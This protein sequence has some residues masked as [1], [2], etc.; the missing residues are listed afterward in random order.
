[1]HLDPRDV[2]VLLFTQYRPRVADLL[3]VPGGHHL[4]GLHFRRYPKYPATHQLIFGLPE[5]T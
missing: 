1:M 4:W 3:C 2:T 5:R